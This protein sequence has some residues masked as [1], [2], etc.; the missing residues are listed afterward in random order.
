M[1]SF[2]PRVPAPFSRALFMELKQREMY[3]SFS[4][5]RFLHFNGAPYTDART[6]GDGEKAHRDRVAFIFASW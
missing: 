1:R 5:V 4:L 2:M 3:L 6:S